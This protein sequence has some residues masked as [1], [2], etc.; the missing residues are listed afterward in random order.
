MSKQTVDFTEVV[1]ESQKQALAGITQAHEG[2]LKLAELGMSSLPMAT[3]FPWTMPK[4]K[5]AVQASYDFAGKVLE[6][7][8]AFAVQ[9]TEIVAARV[10]D[11]RK[12]VK[13]A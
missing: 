1:A 8:K 7:Q 9:L 2:M 3:P 11:G 12:T 13:Q 6:E 5:D 10:D 4:P